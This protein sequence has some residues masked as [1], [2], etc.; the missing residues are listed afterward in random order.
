[1]KERRTTQIAI[2][3]S[4]WQ[5]KNEKYIK[6]TIE[7]NNENVTNKVKTMITLHKTRGKFINAY[8]MDA[9]ILGMIFGYRV[10]DG[11][12]C[13]FPD[14]SLDKVK[15]ELESKQISY[16]VVYP[17]R[18]TFV[19]RFDDNKYS[20]Y[21]SKAIENMNYKVKVEK[22]C[23]YIKSATDEQIERILSIL[24]KECIK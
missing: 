16:Q 5:I 2:K 24:E 19:K 22:I 9:Y 13:G 20:E 4:G 21:L 3:Q 7:T 6:E 23:E 18:D 17:D 10:L 14:T 1:M 8:E 12:K 11:K 15:N